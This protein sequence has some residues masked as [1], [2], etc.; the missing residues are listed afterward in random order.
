MAENMVFLPRKD[1]LS[2]EELEEVCGAFI[3][4]GVRKIRLTGGEPLVRKNLMKLV[5]TLGVHKRA[6][7]LDEI[8]LTTNGTQLARYANA[9]KDNGVER[10]NVSLDTLNPKTFTALTRRDVL[11]QVLAG[12]DAAQEAGLK[13]K[14][15]TVALKNTNDED[16]PRIMEWA[17]AR[18]MDMTLIEVMPMGDVGSDRVDQYLPLTEIRERLSL[19]HTLIDTPLRTGG[20]ARYVR[21]QETGGILGFITPLTN[22]FCAGCNRLRLTCTGQIYMCLG[23]ADRVDLRAAIR[24]SDPDAA[25]NSALDDAMRR[26]PE[27]HNF[28]ISEREAAPAVARHMSVTGG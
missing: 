23:H 19:T 27:R 18:A 1:L 28:D 15:N 26:K 13:I 5:E 3:A 14:V 10:I 11:P 16:I 7:H 9:L 4:R 17:H 12:I 2:I 24:S 8:T 22:N 25:V 20:P 21:V 6:G